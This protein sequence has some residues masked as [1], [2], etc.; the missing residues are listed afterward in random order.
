M[1]RDKRW[2]RV[3]KGYHAMANGIGVNAESPEDAV[4][5]GYERGE[6]DEF[7]MP[8]VVD[9]RGLIE[10]GDSIIFFN[11]RPDRAREI[12]R[13]FVENGFHEFSRKPLLIHFTSMTQYDATID[14]PVAFPAQNLDETLGEVI[15][16][17]GL[18]QLRIAETEKYAHVTYFFNGGKEEPNPNEDRLLVPSPKVAT[19]DLK[20]EMS[21]YEVTDAL[22]ERIRGG[23]Y[24]LIIVNYANPDMVGH[25]G[26]FDAAVLAV[27]AVDDC[28]GRVV[29]QM[30]G[31]GGGVL[32]TADHG[33]AEKMKDEVTGQM[34]TAH[35]TN[36]VPF[37]LILN[38]GIKH[39]LRNDG[40]LADVAPT[41]LELL[42]LPKPHA[43][44]GR[45]LIVR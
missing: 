8:T 33:N 5:K 45:S 44:T 3:E 38:D 25:T 19:Y 39:E 17:Q 1:D 32:L 12:T 10:D 7:L 4:I 30:L 18:R 13:A 43:M 23:T 27:E 41:A 26:I 31:R 24:D 35:T 36:P 15:S 34:H 2:D 11:F 40:S 21:A 20:P 29:D 9:P 22:I 28:V 14:V 16:K 6:T 42:K 37:L